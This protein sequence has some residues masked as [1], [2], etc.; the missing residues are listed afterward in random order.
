MVTTRYNFASI[1]RITQAL[2]IIGVRRLCESLDLCTYGNAKKSFLVLLH[3]LGRQDGKTI[4]GINF[5]CKNA[6]FFA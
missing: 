5:L 2:G 4:K 1:F 6:I 3:P